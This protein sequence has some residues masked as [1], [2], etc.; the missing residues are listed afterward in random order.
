MVQRRSELP[1]LERVVT[2]T[3]KFASGRGIYGPQYSTVSR[4]TRVR[5]LEISA[6]DQFLFLGTDEV[7][8]QGI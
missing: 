3:A 2:R 5:R 8:R 6:K 4:P 1:S 7:F